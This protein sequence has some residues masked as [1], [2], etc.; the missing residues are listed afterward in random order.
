[1]VVGESVTRSMEISRN[2]KESLFLIGG[3]VSWYS[4]GCKLL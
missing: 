3:Y 1:M 2:E 4:S